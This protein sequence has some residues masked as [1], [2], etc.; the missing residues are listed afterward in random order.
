MLCPESGI[1]IYLG[2]IFTQGVIHSKI[3]LITNHEL[4]LTGANRM[5]LFGRKPFCAYNTSFEM[6]NVL[7]INHNC[8]V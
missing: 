4:Y 1:L 3:I 2:S 5:Q 8:M 6:R 7:L